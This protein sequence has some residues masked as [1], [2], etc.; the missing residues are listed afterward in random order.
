MKA[1]EVIKA[2]EKRH[3]EA[4]KEWELF[5]ELR[6]GTGYGPV[7]YGKSKESV[8]NPEQR[9]DAW[10]I[11]LYPSRGYERIAYEVKVSRADFLQEIKNPDKRQQALSVSN[12]YYFVTPVG[13]ITLGELPEECGLIEV[14][15]DGT[16]RIKKKALYR[17]IG[18]VPMGLIASIARRGSR[19]ENKGKER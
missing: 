10:A 5:T 15:E 14:K 17:D 13:L 4:G 9:Y 18:E 6:A 2:I 16:S 3:G 1:E 12:Y 19:A 8:N 11:N 7:S